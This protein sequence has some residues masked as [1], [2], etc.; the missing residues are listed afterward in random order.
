MCNV[1]NKSRPLINVPTLLLS[2]VIQSGFMSLKIC[3]LFSHCEIVLLDDKNSSCRQR[4]PRSNE[5]LN[6]L[7]RRSKVS[8]NNRVRLDVFSGRSCMS[9]RRYVIEREEKRKEE[10]LV[11]VVSSRK[12]FRNNPAQKTQHLTLS[13]SP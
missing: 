2:T 13:K 9:D 11:E 3:Y 7:I 8:F 1:R 6:V 4:G 12:T 10:R 5:D